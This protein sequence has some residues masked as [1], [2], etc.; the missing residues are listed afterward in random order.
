[1][2][3]FRVVNLLPPQA[4][5]TLAVTTAT[6]TWNF[7]Q[8][9]Q[10][11]RFQTAIQNHQCAET[12]ILE[13][14]VSVSDG[15][16][17]CDRA[18]DELTPILLGASYLLGLSVTVK[19]SIPFSG[20]MIMEPG[21]HWPRERAVGAGTPVINSD[22]ELVTYL[23]SFVAA[24]P[25][26]AQHEKA[27]LLVHHWLDALACWSFED[28]Y[29]STT[30][31]LQVVAATEEDRQGKELSFLQGVTDAS[32]RFHLA[33]LSADFKNMRNDLVH[34][35]R[36]SASRFPGKA[37]EDCAQVAAEV[38]NWIDRYLHAAL[39]IGPILKQ[40]FKKADFMNLNAYSL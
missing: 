4:S 29:L 5:K 20:C 16:A 21:S 17:A 25:V 37:I 15:A 22:A 40:R 34:D 14:A 24:W 10:F 39:N 33:P 36:L 9:S 38:M 30:T 13:H 19:R 23:Q 31:L 3:G 7:T 8:E 35:G 6:G 12:Y 2:I 26:T 11:A 27:L 18:F 32:T 1:M 28:M